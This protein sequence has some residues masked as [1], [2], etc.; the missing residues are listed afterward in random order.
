MGLR[1]LSFPSVTVQTSGGAL[2][3][4]GLSLD[5]IMGLLSRHAALK[6]AFELII[7]KARKGDTV[8]NEDVAL[9]ALDLINSVPA[10]VAE[11]IA[12]AS[13]ARA[14]DP[15]FREY[16]LLAMALNIAE[17]IDALEKIASQ[18]F[19]SDM[20]PGKMFALLASMAQASGSAIRGLTA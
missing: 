9:V 20:P 7:T 8:V 12:L 6:G 10:A 4:R 2:A 5:H 13:G 17:Q 3:V 1:D 16:T 11:I 14:D 19:T 18:T 15:D